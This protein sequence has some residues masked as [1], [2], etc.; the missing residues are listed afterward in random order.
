MRS[1]ALEVPLDQPARGD[2]KEKRWFKFTVADNES[3]PIRINIKNLYG[4]G[5][6]WATV[7]NSAN[8][9]IAG[10]PGPCSSGGDCTIRF[11]SPQSD[12]YYLLTSQFA[13]TASFEL[14]V[15]VYR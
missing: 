13:A 15:S 9:E 6:L 2:T 4:S 12:T 7:Y 11:T 8:T 10:G 14:T 1:K 5:G 3:V